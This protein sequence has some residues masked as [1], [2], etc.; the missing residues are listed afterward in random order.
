MM[1]TYALNFYQ[2]QKHVLQNHASILAKSLIISFQ[3][4]TESVCFFYNNPVYIYIYTHTHTHTYI[5]SCDKMTLPLSYI[6]CEC[7]QHDGILK[8]KI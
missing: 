2:Y 5:Y 6:W 7:K 8:A 1:V 4:N 3:Y